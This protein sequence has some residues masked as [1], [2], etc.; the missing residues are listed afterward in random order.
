MPSFSRENGSL[1]DDIQ[2]TTKKS[3]DNQSQTFFV[4]HKKHWQVTIILKR[5]P[6]DERC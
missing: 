6:F 3:R 1:P 4:G 5:A 2:M